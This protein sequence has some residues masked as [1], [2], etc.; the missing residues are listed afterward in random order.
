MAV[1][2]AVML[3]S[4]ASVSGQETTSAEKAKQKELEELKK[5]QMEAEKDLQMDA[6]KEY[7]R[8]IR[9]I[10]E[11]RRR[12][13]DMSTKKVIVIPDE[14]TWS[15]TTPHLDNFYFYDTYSSSKPGSSWNYSRQVMEASFTNEF[16]M[17]A[18][19]EDGNVSLSVSGNCAEGSISVA[20]VMP[21][22]K[23]LS[24]VVIDANGSLNWRKSFEENE[25]SNWKNG[26]WIFRIRAKAAT[27]NFRISMTSN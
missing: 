26:K 10:D 5:A 8:Q 19:G 25:G 11:I 13:E 24:E 9:D 16:T 22:G 17:D 4:A 14:G 6:K 15:M 1:I 20:I 21:D 23:Q 27:G 18:G 2:L 3:L 7:E 12:A